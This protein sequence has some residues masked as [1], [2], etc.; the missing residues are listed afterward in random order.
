MRDTDIM[1]DLAAGGGESG[2]YSP[3]VR[4]HLPR[5]D[6]QEAETRMKEDS[7]ELVHKQADPDYETIHF[8]RGGKA[9]SSRNTKQLSRETDN[10]DKIESASV[11]DFS[12]KKRELVLGIDRKP[13]I[14]PL[15]A[16]KLD[17]CDEDSA[18]DDTDTLDLETFS[19]EVDVNEEAENA[20]DTSEDPSDSEHI[21]HKPPPA[22]CPKFSNNPFL[23]HQQKS[24]TKFTKNP[25]RPSP[26]SD[27]STKKFIQRNPDES[28][29]NVTAALIR[30]F[31]ND[32]SQTS[33]AET[34][35]KT[36]K[37]TTK[38]LI[39]KVRIFSP[40]MEIYLKHII[41]YKCTYLLPVQ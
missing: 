2:P 10:L 33:S 25:T 35:S 6:A 14:K 21:V 37:T 12:S 19:L 15:S 22:E 28:K 41:I 7:F 27:R 5:E 36:V 3:M 34:E 8:N 39:N 16:F 11:L 32:K 9:A 26:R 17:K 40:D 38:Q 30:Q 18:S 13:E 20:S 24:N 1:Q 29:N 31:N 23:K 4:K